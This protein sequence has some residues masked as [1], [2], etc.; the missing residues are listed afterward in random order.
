MRLGLRLEPRHPSLESICSIDDISS[1]VVLILIILDPIVLIDL[2]SMH[3][4]LPKIILPI[5]SLPIINRIGLILQSLQNLS[6]LRI[7]IRLQP[8][9]RRR[10]TRNIRITYL[11]QR[12]RRQCVLRK[13][14]FKLVLPSLAFPLLRRSFNEERILRADGSEVLEV[15]V[16]GVVEVDTV[17]CGVAGCFLVHWHWSPR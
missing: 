14:D 3:D 10:P 5:C 11:I 16:V 13:E 8:S 17:R 15:V 1:F 9:N 2:S 12:V 4:V 7:H 6:N